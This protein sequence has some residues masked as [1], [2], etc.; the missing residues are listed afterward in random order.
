LFPACNKIEHGFGKIADSTARQTLYRIL[1]N[2]NGNTTE[3]SDVYVPDYICGCVY[4]A[5]NRAGKRIHY[6]HI[7]ENFYQ[8]FDY[9]ALI[10]TIKKESDC[11]KTALIIVNYFATLDCVET[12]RIIKEL[13]KELTVI[14]DN[15]QS[16]FDMRI[17]SGADYQF[18][19][20]RKWI[21][22][23]DGSAVKTTKGCELK[24]M[25]LVQS[26]SAVESITAG[27]LKNYK[28]FPEIRDKDYLMH[29]EK[30][31]EIINASW[32]VKVSSFTQTILD[33]ID[34]DNIAFQRRKNAYS[35]CEAIIRNE[36]YK[37]SAEKI[38]QLLDERPS[39]V[40]MFVP[41]FINNRDYVRTE[42]MNNN[43]FCP[44]HWPDGKN[45]DLTARELSLVIDQRY[46]ENDMKKIANVLNS[47]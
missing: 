28:N 32:N 43:I 2:R 42:L 46:D 19:S 22:V 15:V 35:L 44:V 23:P 31:E 6:Y 34:F 30:G 13:N 33:N 17:D 1:E 37:F 45:K 47:I 29:F 8:N 24:P 9:K 7:D 21:P 38:I 4:E 39:M 18:T 26:T 25:E 41:I 11:K 3:L 27:F 40:P 12:V 20:L 16:L 36:S 14:I 10:A 5:I